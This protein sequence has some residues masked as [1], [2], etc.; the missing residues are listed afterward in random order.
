MLISVEKL[1]R[2]WQVTPN[3]VLHVGAHKAEEAGE[4]ERYNWG[5]TIWV[6]AQSDL[7]EEISKKLD[8]SKNI[9]INA[10]I[11]GESG[12]KLNFKV[13]S[14]SQSSSLLDFGSHQLD[15]P[16]VI[17]TSTYDVITTTL[18]EILTDESTFDF[19]NLDIQ[20]V[21]LEALKGMGKYL[22]QAKWI[23]TEVNKKEVYQGCSKI[24]DIDFFLNNVGFKRVATRWVKRQGWGDA[25][26]IRTREKITIRM[27]FIAIIDQI[28]WIKSQIP[29]PKRILAKAKRIIMKKHLKA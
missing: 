28:T 1:S 16:D 29:S 26:Y 4:Y 19:I 14:N 15:Y 8:P 2:I 24:T 18:A 20:G 17:I 13:S 5:Y 9:V 22:N 7:A 11:W 27:R 25:L 10:A 6:E 12:V 23:Y 3:G 21:E